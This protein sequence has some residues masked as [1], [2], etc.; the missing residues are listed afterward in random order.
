MLLVTQ[1]SVPALSVPDIARCPLVCVC[2]APPPAALAPPPAVSTA[3][4]LQ[5]GLQHWLHC[6]Q[7]RR[8]WLSAAAH[9]SLSIR[10]REPDSR[11]AGARQGPGQVTQAGVGSSGSHRYFTHIV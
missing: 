5:Q 10:W 11:S 7:S 2:E 4:S 3:V 9:C 1:F 6:T 8:W